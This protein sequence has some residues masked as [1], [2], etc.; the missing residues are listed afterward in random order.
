MLNTIESYQEQLDDL[1]NS[2]RVQQAFELQI[3]IPLVYAEKQR[4]IEALEEAKRDEAVMRTGLDR[5]QMQ[6]AA[7]PANEKAIDGSQQEIDGLTEKLFAYKKNE[8]RVLNAEELLR[9]HEHPAKYNEATQK[10]EMEMASLTRR[11]EREKRDIQEIQEN[12]NINMDYLDKIM[13]READAIRT[14]LAGREAEDSDSALDT[15]GEL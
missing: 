1:C 5:M 14:A 6:I 9:I 8:M 11:I 10:I 4:L 15:N 3:A 7:I 13:R 12:E 2:D